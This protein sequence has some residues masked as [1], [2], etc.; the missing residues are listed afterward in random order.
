MAFHPAN[1]ELLF[2]PDLGSDCVRVFSLATPTAPVALSPLRVAPGAGPRHV[3][4]HPLLSLVYIVNELT[5]TVTV[6]HVDPASGAGTLRQTVSTL[7]ADCITPSFCAAIRLSPDNSHVYVSNRGHDSIA[8]FA[9][10]ADGL[11]ALQA[12]EPT[13]GRC[14]RDINFVGRH[15]VAANQVFVA[16]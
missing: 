2:V 4:I 6:F 10:G 3:A 15:L 16:V 8:V 1:P 9:V 5:S 14:P 12:C 11:L 13:Q 7:P